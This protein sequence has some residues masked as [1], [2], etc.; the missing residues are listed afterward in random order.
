M[1]RNYI[2]I[3]II[4]IS[5]ISYGCNSQKSISE[6]TL[7]N[8]ETTPTIE[9]YDTSKG[10]DH[11]QPET[12]SLEVLYPAFEIVNS[13][14]QYGYINEDGIFEIPP[15]YDYAEVFIDGRAVVNNKDRY[16]VINTNGDI[17]FENNAPIRNFS[18]GYAVFHKET[19]TD[20]LMGYIDTNGNIALEP[21]YRMAEDF[22]KDKKAI[23]S[24][25]QNSYSLIDDT[26]AVL[27]NYITEEYINLIDVKDGYKIFHKEGDWNK[28]GIIN[29]QNEV[30]FDSNHHDVYIMGNNLFAMSKENAEGILPSETSPMAIFDLNK[31]QLTD[32]MFYEVND[33]NGDYACA[34]DG[35]FTYLIAKD[36]KIIENLPKV[37]GIGSLRMLG[38]VIQ[39]KVDG[40]LFYLKKDGSVIW[41]EITSTY[42]TDQINVKRNKLRPDRFTLIHYPELEGLEDNNVQT[43][44]NSKLKALFERSKEEAFEDYVVYVEDDFGIELSKDLLIVN[45]TGY[46]YPSGAAHGMPINDYYYFN[47]KTGN[48]YTLKELFKSNSLYVS[49]LNRILDKMILDPA[50][51]PEGLIFTESFYGIDSKQEF[52]LTN[53]SLI[54]YFYPYEIA[55]YAAGFPEFEIPFA[56]LI[57]EIDTE[58]EFFNSFTHDKIVSEEL[59]QKRDMIEVMD[60]L[61]RQYEKALIAAINIDYFEYVEPHLKEGSNLY[62]SQKDLVKKLYKQGIY[63]EYIGSKV[64]NVIYDEANKKY[65]IYVTEEIGIKYPNKE[66]QTKN[67]AYLYTAVPVEELHRYQLTEIEKWK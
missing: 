39:A 41:H 30:I 50:A 52:R 21:I 33:F 40:E 65:L 3:L 13:E 49:N 22:S 28:K 46:D 2:L 25:K 42:L 1:K 35:Q 53:D 8:Q 31:K 57:N 20:T 32:Y 18:N 27:E 51:H 5:T 7:K 38:D 44:I 66:K 6:E 48:Q 62:R 64:E 63:E 29:L 4:L 34:S 24:T 43:S 26:G 14:K 60:A 16:Q 17:I 37:E 56:K 54:I 19:D 59:D 11:E 36:G 45:R 55:A 47:I 23:V 58:G 10:P 9:A 61:I 15:T 67:F 12:T